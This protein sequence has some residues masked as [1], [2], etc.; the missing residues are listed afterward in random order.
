[1]EIED[2]EANRLVIGE[3][4]GAEIRAVVSLLTV[5]RSV[6]SVVEDGVL[7]TEL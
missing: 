5:R 6:L 4:Q 1:M 3:L 7:T 2:G